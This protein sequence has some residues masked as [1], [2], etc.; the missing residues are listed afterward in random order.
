MSTQD[1]PRGADADR[2]HHAEIGGGTNPASGGLWIRNLLLWALTGY[3]KARKTESSPRTQR[4]GHVTAA[5]QEAWLLAR[6]DKHGFTINTGDDKERDMVVRDR[7]IHKFQRDGR[8][9]TLATA[10]FEGRLTVTD[11]DTLRA[12]LTHGIGPAKGYGCG[13]LTLAR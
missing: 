6:A 5:Q 1:K 9:V 12:T 8:T 3:G 7:H 4:L 13:L 2:K 10:T 11:P